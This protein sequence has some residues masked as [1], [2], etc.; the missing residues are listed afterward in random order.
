MTLAGVAA[1][2]GVTT[3]V[4]H[5]GVADALFNARFQCPRV[6]LLQ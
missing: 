1:V 6:G 5:T 3:P 2:A 4:R